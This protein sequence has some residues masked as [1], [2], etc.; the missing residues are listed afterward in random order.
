MIILS[1]SREIDGCFFLY[2]SFCLRHIGNVNTYNVLF[3]QAATVTSDPPTVF[4]STLQRSMTDPSGRWLEGES[5]SKLEGAQWLW[6][7]I[8]KIVR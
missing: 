6:I 3:D 2:F 1:N 5:T 4:G 7:K 8:G